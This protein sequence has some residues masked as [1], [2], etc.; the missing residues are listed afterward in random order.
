MSQIQ[1]SR[2]L[3]VSS[4]VNSPLQLEAVRCTAWV[5]STLYFIS[6]QGLLLDTWLLSFCYCYSL[7]STHT[8]KCAP[9]E[10]L[11]QIPEL[12]KGTG[13]VTHTNVQPCC[14]TIISPFT[15]VKW[16]KP[17]R[18]KKMYSKKDANAMTSHLNPSILL[19]HLFR[20]NLKQIH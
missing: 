5:Y 8:H 13:V 16:L 9:D 14:S 15:H 4:L 11:A 3:T 18:S 1:V 20:F 17:L 2:Q 7:V 12:P 6:V 19:F 10:V